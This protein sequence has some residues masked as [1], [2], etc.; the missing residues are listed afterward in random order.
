MS[1][2]H[3]PAEEQLAGFVAGDCPSAEAV[4]IREHAATCPRCARWLHET[5]KNESILPEIVRA[6]RREEGALTPVTTLAS[7]T[8]PAPL[9]QLTDVE[10]AIEG[11]SLLRGIGRGG[12][13]IVFE[14]IQES[15]KRP[16]A[17]KVLRDGAH[18]TPS[19]LRRFEREI[20]LAASLKHAGIVTI[21]HS[22]KT[23]DGHL[24]C[25]MDLV[26]GIPLDEYVRSRQLTLKQTLALFQ[27]VC[28]AVAHAHQKGVIHRDLKPSN[29]LV[30]EEGCPRVLDFG[31][32][33]HAEALSDPL[34][35]SAGQVIGTLPYASPEHVS[36]DGESID[37]RSDV[38]ALGVMLYRLLTGDYPYRVDGSWQDVARQILDTPP[39]PPTRRWHSD[40]GV[41]G[42]PT[43]RSRNGRCPIDGEL[44]T[45]VLKALAKEPQRRYQTADELGRDIGRYLRNEPIEARRDSAAYVLRKA[46]RR[47]RTPVLIS[48]T[49]AIGLAVAWTAFAYAAA[50][51][52]LNGKLYQLATA[53][54]TATGAHLAMQARNLTDAYE[55]LENYPQASGRQEF[56]SLRHDAETDLLR[57]LE[58]ALDANDFGPVA[59]LFAE[60]PNVAATLEKLDTPP[61][62]NDIGKR[63]RHRLACWIRVPPP[64][65]KA[66]EIQACIK[67]LRNLDPTSTL[68]AWADDQR[69]KLE[70]TFESIGPANLTAVYDAATVINRVDC[71]SREFDGD[72]VSLDFAG[73]CESVARIEY[74]LGE[75]GA[76]GTVSL[77]VT[78]E[79]PEPA[80]DASWAEASAYLF[81]ASRDTGN[82]ASFRVLRAGDL[83]YIKA[84]N[85]VTPVVRDLP[86]ADPVRFELRYHA[87]RSTC[88]VLMNCNFVIEETPCPA[89][90]RVE[91]VQVH[92]GLA[93]TLRVH[94][95]EVAT[96]DA[97]LKVPLGDAVPLVLKDDLNFQPVAVYPLDTPSVVVQDFDGD[98]IPE[99]AAGSAS[100]GRLSLYHYEPAE[101]ALESIATYGFPSAHPL[102]PVTM[103]GSH[104]AVTNFR[105]GNYGKVMDGF[106]LIEVSSDMSMQ[107]IEHRYDSNQT[108]TDPARTTF[109]KLCAGG[110]RE[111]LA[112]GLAY[113]ERRIAFFSW[114][115]TSLAA[116]FTSAFVHADEGERRA[117]DIHSLIPWDQNEDGEDDLLIG[118]GD[119]GGVALLRMRN[120]DP[121]GSP[122][123]LVLSQA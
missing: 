87:T 122:Q 41:H 92:A 108:D 57:S 105:D 35:S 45:I 114:P 40:S 42:A 65:G 78:M 3:C 53:V 18:A 58:A 118:W 81:G 121:D 36:A 97:L 90:S 110:S 96:T 7:P 95:L 39:T 55:L 17:L 83:L 60:S 50:E 66:A 46:I 12:Q 43:R 32:A 107:G 70:A 48:V 31:L 47:Q 116:P 76:A 1:T 100:A 14:A 26:A 71:V 5:V 93:T 59:Y 74:P 44:E 79:L 109:A 23:R 8:D 51:R 56:V 30:D 91:A 89:V 19:A 67:A 6:L 103:V 88:D 38:Y 25:A 84:P 98:G 120:G 63:L 61:D 112:V 72:C 29:V 106:N 101:E 68:P 33:K 69:D 86:P 104:L 13:G 102:I 9:A 28:A 117:A 37:T 77:S 2:D 64:A 22:G 54:R 11:Y 115:T 16:V 34:L 73:N 24:F 99:I 21:L 80:H 52:A 123:P 20:E 62:A 82:A 4:Y 94:A 85:V 27:S 113:K 10:L 75:V 49:A 111:V 119:R 15:T